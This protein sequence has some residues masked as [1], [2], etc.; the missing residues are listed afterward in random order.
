MSDFI[1]DRTAFTFLTGD[2]FFQLQAVA[3]ALLRVVRLAAGFL[4]RLGVVVGAAEAGLHG[5]RVRPIGGGDGRLASAVS[6]DCRSKALATAPHLNP[7]HV[8]HLFHSSTPKRTKKPPCAQQE[9]QCAQR[10]ND[11]LP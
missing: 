5:S 11:G 4:V 6:R 10:L 9:S 7:T 8:A 1:K 2:P 3:L